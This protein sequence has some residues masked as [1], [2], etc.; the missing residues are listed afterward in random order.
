MDRSSD[1]DGS[2]GLKSDDLKSE[3]KEEEK[4]QTQEF[5]KQFGGLG[6]QIG[7]L[8]PGEAGN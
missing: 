7:S 6:A 3:Q 5:M 1:H 8:F 4:K 2:Q